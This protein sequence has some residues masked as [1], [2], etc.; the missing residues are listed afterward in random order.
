MRIS[1]RLWIGAA[2]AACLIAV[3]FTASTSAQSGTIVACY[4]SQNGQLRL[5]S[6]ASQCLPSETVITWNQ[7]GT[8]GATGATGPTGPQGPAGATG[9]T[10]PAGPAGAAGATGAQGATGATGA[11]GPTGA[12]GPEGHVG[13]QGPP[14][15]DGADGATGPTGPAGVAELP[16]VGAFTP[17]QLVQSAILT[18]TSESTA[19]SITTCNGLKLNGVDVRIAVAEAQRICNTVTG[20]GFSS[21]SGGGTASTPHFIWNGTNWALSSAADPPMNVLNCNK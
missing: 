4:K 7:A 10:G 16:P 20:L 5:V 14:G 1:F 12:D 15:A 11:T 17:T 21:A 8:T 2:I 6:A 18:C 3:A 13:P 19:G 9:A